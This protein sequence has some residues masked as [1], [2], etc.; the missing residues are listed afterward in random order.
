[1]SI[2]QIPIGPDIKNKNVYLSIVKGTSVDGWIKERHY[3]KS[4]PL[5]ATLRMAFKSGSHEVL[6]C[7]LWGH[8]TARKLDQR[9]ILEL[10]RMF[11]I[12]DTDPFIESKCLAMAR[13]HIRKHCPDIK[14]L[15]A[16]S[17]MGAGHEGTV[18]KADNWYVLGTGKGGRWGTR[19]GRQTA[20]RQ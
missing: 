8:P 5:G 20:T 18:Y 19:A 3:L 4:S 13:K 12:D 9:N 6:G 11:F 2:Y 16:Y 14:G 7:M 1:M 15:I 10:F 17:S